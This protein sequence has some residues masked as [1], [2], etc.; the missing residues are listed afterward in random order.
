MTMR[1]YLRPCG[2]EGQPKYRVL[3]TGFFCCQRMGKMASNI[4]P[5]ESSNLLY[6]DALIQF[7]PGCGKRVEII[8]VIPIP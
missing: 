8:M 1:F 6:Y 2:L 7:C 4:Y 5:D 3:G